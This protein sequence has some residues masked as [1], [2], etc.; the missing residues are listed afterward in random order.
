MKYNV[1]GDEKNGFYLV[2]DDGTKQI[3]TCP[4]CAK[5]LVNR[6]AAEILAYNMEKQ[7][8]ALGKLN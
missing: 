6:M 1:K 3:D 2:S 4:C 7:D 8:E 5:S